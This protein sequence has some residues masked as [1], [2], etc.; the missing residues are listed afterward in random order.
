MHLKGGSR[1][2]DGAIAVSPASDENHESVGMSL[3]GQIM[4]T[5]PT[6]IYMPKGDLTYLDPFFEALTKADSQSVRVMHYG[7]SQLEGDRMTSVIREYLQS[8]FGGMGPGMLAAVQPVGSYTVSQSVSPSGI[9]CYR[10]YGPTD[11]R[12]S[13]HRYGPM[14]QMSRIEGKATLNYTCV[15]GDK[16]KHSRTFNRVTVLMKGSGSISAFAAGQTV[17]LKDVGGDANGLRI[18]SANLAQAVSRVTV[19]IAGPMD[20]YGVLLDGR[21]G[22]QVDNIAQ[23]GSSGTIFTAI[24]RNTIEPYFRDNRVD[25]II[26]QFGGNA[27]PYLKTEAKREYFQKEVRRQVALFRSIAPKAKILYIGPA[28]MSTCVGG[29]MVSYPMMADV[30][31][32]LREAVNAE[33]AAF[34]D[35]YAA[36]GGDGAMVRWVNAT[37]ALGGPDYIHFTPR[38][39]EKMAGIFVETLEMYYKYYRLRKFGSDSLESDT[40]AV[41]TA[42]AA[43]PKPA[44]TSAPTDKA[45]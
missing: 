3:W 11:W 26:L 37:P 10:I 25:L 17:S 8:T 15:G 23:R 20:V 22:V 35:M 5:S 29:E 7:D 43:T 28:D 31:A 36:Q 12:A 21:V 9:G 4:K 13:H 44:T 40:T 18:F 27:V 39:A 6:R 33:G 32:C 41:D 30:E 38:G 14:C 42:K 2:T 45:S 19:N 16:Y 1:W 24:D 34:W